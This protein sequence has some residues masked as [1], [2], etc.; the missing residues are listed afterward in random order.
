[1]AHCGFVDDPENGVSGAQLL[2]SYGPT[3]HVDIGFDAAYTPASKEP[4]RAGIQGVHAL[5][6]TGATESCIDG[7]LAIQLNLPLVDRRHVAG[8]HGSFEVNVY[9]AQIHVP[10]LDK[11]MYGAFTGVHL[12]AGGQLHQALMGRTFL[13]HFTMLYEGHSGQ[14]RITA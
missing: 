12:R 11:T 1:M 6:D 8:A 10:A 2:V 3:L 4:P 13:Q 9:L 5:V 14:V 7:A